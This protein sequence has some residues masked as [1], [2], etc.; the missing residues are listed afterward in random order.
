[1]PPERRD[2]NRG[3]HER[4]KDIDGSHHSDQIDDDWTE[5]VRFE[6]REQHVEVGEAGREEREHALDDAHARRGYESREQD[7][8]DVDDEDREGRAGARGERKRE[9]CEPDARGVHLA[10]RDERRLSRGERV[11]R[12]QRDVLHREPE[13]AR[14]VE[15]QRDPDHHGGA[16]GEIGRR[17]EE[18]RDDLRRDEARAPVTRGEDHGVGARLVLEREHRRERHAHGEDREGEEGHAV[19]DVGPS[20]HVAVLGLATLDWTI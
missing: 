12:G 18:R 6:C 3:R 17:P 13:A 2:G 16:G 8:H 14:P 20:A 10:E 9:T 11:G 15:R 1:M 7:Q 4:Q 19:D 5:P